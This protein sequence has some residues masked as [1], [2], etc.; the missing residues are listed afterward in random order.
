MRSNQSR[1]FV[2][3]M[4][5]VLVGTLAGCP[6]GPKIPGRGGSKVDP[7]TCG[8][9]AASDAGR[10]LKAFLE[11]TVKLEETVKGIEVEVRTGCDAMAKELGVDAKGETKAV[12]DRVFAQIKEDLSAGIKA[13]ARLTIDY[14]P[15]VC[16]VSVDAAASFAAECEASA[17]GEVKVECTGTCT[18]TCAGEC[19]GTCKGGSGGSECNG[20][21]EGVCKGSCSGGCDGAADVQASAECEAKAEVYASAE[22]ECTPAELNVEADASVVVDQP[23]TDRVIAAMK[24]GLPQILTVEAK[25]RPVARA[26]KTWAATARALGDAGAELAKSFEDQALCISGQI[27]AAVAAV[28]S[29][30]A[31]VSVSVEVS[32]SASGSVASN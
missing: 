27:S 20:E 4:M 29:I 23:R 7:N 18:G 1:A 30:E 12:C 9:Y 26:A 31:N 6:G 28:A 24:A 32:A 22:V 25:L 10:K 21:C 14:K 5:A 17:S 8:N 11:A 16:T 19:D 15:A 2:A 3:I 13:D